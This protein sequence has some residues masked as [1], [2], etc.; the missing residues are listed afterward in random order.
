MAKELAVLISMHI[1]IELVFELGCMSGPVCISFDGALN[2]VSCM[3][4]IELTSSS[5]E[6]TYQ[7]IITKPTWVPLTVWRPFIQI[8]TCIWSASQI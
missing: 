5:A 2:H 4:S 7:L 1:C 6:I 8:S 3:S